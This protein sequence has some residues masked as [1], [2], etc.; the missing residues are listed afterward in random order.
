MVIDKLP[1]SD[2]LLDK[3]KDYAAKNGGEKHAIDSLPENELKAL[4]EITSYVKGAPFIFASDNSAAYKALAL[5]LQNHSPKKADDE[6]ITAIQKYS[7]GNKGFAHSALK[8]RIDQAKAYISKLKTNKSF[9]GSIHVS[10]N[11][12][13]LSLESFIQRANHFPPEI[14]AD[15]KNAI[16]NS[17]LYLKLK[18]EKL[19]DVLPLIPEFEALLSK[20]DQLL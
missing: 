18:N 15:F 6:S 2:D 16:L 4:Y 5:R 17:P 14:S 3:W 10:Q 7:F 20:L 12:L 9:W 8:D 11:T 1:S 13:L 19:S